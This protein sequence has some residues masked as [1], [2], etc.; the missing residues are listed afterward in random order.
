MRFGRGGADLRPGLIY[1]SVKGTPMIRPVG[2]GEEELRLAILG[3]GYVGLVMATC[4]STLGFAVRC[5]DHNVERIKGLQRGEAPFFEPGLSDALR[6]CVAVGRLSFGTSLPET[7]GAAAVFIAVGTLDEHGEWSARE[8]NRAVGE[9]AA[10]AE[11]PRIL[12]LRSTVMPGTTNR[13]AVLAADQDARVEICL[14]P[15]F[16]RQG[17]AMADF[18]HPDR[19]VIGLT[20]P[21]IQSRALPI[22]ETI[23]AQAGAPIV[24]TD[25]ASAEL[26]KVGANAFLAVKAGFANEI[27]RIAAATG[28]DVAQV[29]D[30]IGLDGRIG[31]AYLTPGPGFGGS[32]LPSQLRSL[33][34]RAHEYGVAT[35]LLDAVDVSNGLQAEWVVDQL[36]EA[37]G[38]LANKRVAILGLTFKAG[39]DDVRESP[40]LTVCKV[41]AAR[42]AS[43]AGHD[44]MGRE[45]AARYARAANL[46]LEVSDSPLSAARAADAVVV[47]TDWPDYHVLDWGPIAA[48]LTGRTV[49]DARGVVD[50]ACAARFGLSVIVHGRPAV[51][52]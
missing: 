46:G 41:L 31:R 14:N 29:V 39:T 17:S 32:C 20:R 44:P 49:L 51:V 23:Y 38:D 27:A 47:A 22:L 18:L 8:V 25:A 40:A 6:E 9:L 48:A 50:V 1:R 45:A 36:E 33:P 10:D 34:A 7:H 37:I 13:L 16:T 3:A 26:I 21:A 19:V 15:E 35:P 24:V 11:A 4:L 28:A 5:I 30:A 43:V 42:G 12:I 52:S 2:E